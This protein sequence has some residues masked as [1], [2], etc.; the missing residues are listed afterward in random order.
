MLEPA[1]P[2]AGAPSPFLAPAPV[3]HA[4]PLGFARF[5]LTA[6]RNPIEI[7]G[8]R[9]FREPV[10]RA[11]WLQVPTIIV[12]DPASIRHCLVENAANY[13]MQPLRQ[14]ILRPLLRD[15]LL[16]AEGELWRRTRRSIAPV[17]TPRN[18]AGLA[19]LME[20][21]SR[22]FAERLGVRDGAVVDASAQMT[23]LTYDILQATL[24]TDDIQGEPAAFAKAMETF[25][26]RMGRVDPLD[27]L[28][29][30][31]F[32][33][34]I[35]RLMGR[36]A[37][38]Y[39]RRLITETA[40]RRREAMA[41]DPAGVPRD[42][43]TLLLEAD[44]LSASEI[45]DNIITFIGAGHETTARA[46]G[47]TLYLLSQA[48]DERA[49]VEH[50]L[51]ERLP[52]LPDPREWP[53]ALPQTRAAF[54][55]AMRLYPPAPSLNRTAIAADRVLDTDI[56]AGASLL[57]MPWL[58]HRHERLWD[59]P[60][61]FMPERFLP[62]NRERIDRFQY[63]PFG[64]GPRV[65]IGQSFAMQEGVIALAALLRHLRFDFVGARPPYPVQ[66]ITVQPR[67]GLAM[68]ITRRQRMSGGSGRA[69]SPNE[70]GEPK[71]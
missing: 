41:R 3:P 27:L 56:P 46:L 58:V 54:E 69:R 4:K 14:R 44:G 43:L 37:A 10:L 15:G 31:A 33:P 36:G 21:R 23:L 71:I 12:N 38:R 22:V 19:G 6:S 42:L 5:L 63:L 32:L 11:D 45:E 49:K 9:A 66:K 16:T 8:E 13:A 34:R 51:D 62:G 68:R 18:I 50:E 1:A 67:E 48:P 2:S 35:R 28:D 30:P 52:G 39:F 29:A 70:A 57:V 60:G 64:L 55:E 20:S 17:F 47:W 53:D 25:M 26:G 24:F 59:R 40:E 65:C 61:H 7:W